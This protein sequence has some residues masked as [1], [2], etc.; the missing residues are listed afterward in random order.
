MK[1]VLLAYECIKGELEPRQWIF[2]LHGFLGKGQ[3]WRSFARR[4][5]ALKPHWG[6]VL[7]DLRL[8]GKS[9]DFAPPHTLAQAAEDV[10]ALRSSFTQPVPALL[11]HSFGGKVALRVV[12]QAVNPF[13]QVWLIDFSPWALM[14]KKSASITY[15]VLHILETVEHEHFAN[16]EAFI[17]VL[18]SAGL[19]HSIAEWLSMNGVATNDVFKL[20]L[21]TR[22][23]RSLLDD[24]FAQD[25]MPVLERAS[26]QHTDLYFVLGGLSPLL[27]ESDRTRIIELAKKQSS[28]LKS[29]V[30]AE[31]G[32]DVHM[33]S[34]DGLLA[35]IEKQLI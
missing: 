14:S 13:H 7:V 32:H 15:E 23:L 26:S 34:P 1:N 10:I 24:Y 31:A 19:N 29:Y 2:L 5:V 18:K 35:I 25:L 27:S 20:R 6:A 8:H 12:E 4:L 16:R 33:D 3:N 11:G 21:N 22:G 28:R 30:I 9:I 17:Q